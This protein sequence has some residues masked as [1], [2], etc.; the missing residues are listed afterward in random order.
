MFCKFDSMLG[1]CLFLVDI[2]LTICPHLLQ[3]YQRNVESNQ[4]HGQLEE[5][6]TLNEPLLGL[7]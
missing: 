7:C 5:N 4:S 3:S 2:H 6:D 1:P